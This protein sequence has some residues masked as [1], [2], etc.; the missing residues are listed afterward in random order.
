EPR[1]RHAIG[2]ARDVVET[3]VVAEG[4]GGGIAAMLAANADLEVRPRLAA[5]LHADLDELADSFAINRD[6]GIDLEDALGDVGTEE[7][8]GIVAADAVG[9][10]RQI[11]SAEGEE[12]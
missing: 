8:R 3:D 2:R 4:D 10:L 1:D 6:E 5:A 11:V 9:R 12:L 7:A